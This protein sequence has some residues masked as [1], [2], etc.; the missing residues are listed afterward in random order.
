MAVIIG[1]QGPAAAN[2]V[3]STLLMALPDGVFVLP[4]PRVYG[5]ELGCLVIAP[6]AI[7]HL[8]I[9]DW[10]GVVHDRGEEPWLVEGDDGQ[11]Q[12]EPS[13]LRLLRTARESIARFLADEAP[14]LTPAVRGLLVYRGDKPEVVDGEMR[15][16]KLVSVDEAVVA[17]ADAPAMVDSGLETVEDREALAMAFDQRRLAYRQRASR[18][19]V[20]STGKHARVRRAGW[21]PEEVLH[22]LARHPEPAVQ[23]LL[24]G[25]L[26]EWL[27]TEGALHLADLAT[28]ALSRYPADGHLALEWFLLNSGYMPGPALQLRPAKV[29]L[30]Y[31]L[32]GE[33]ATGEVTID[34]RRGPGYVFG[35][36]TSEDPW[37]SVAPEVLAGRTRI[38]ITGQ[39]S[40]DMQVGEHHGE[41]VI[42]AAG[43]AEPKR[44]PVVAQVRRVPSKWSRWLLRPLLGLATAAPLGAALGWCAA[45][46]L[47]PYVSHGG[48]G[49]PLAI[50]GA[51]LWG[52]MGAIRG[53]QQPPAWPS[54]Y[55][56]AHWLIRV[57][58]WG[59]GAAALMVVSL[60]LTAQL[61]PEA[62]W[63]NTTLPVLAGNAVL[64]C[65]LAVIP[66]TVAEAA[67]NRRSAV[68]GA[69]ASEGQPRPVVRGL[70][71][72]VLLIGLLWGGRALASTP[73]VSLS[74]SAT[75][76][77]ERAQGWYGALEQKVND[78]VDRLYL[79]HLQESRPGRAR[80]PQG[81][82][83]QILGQD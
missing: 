6:S 47:T 60:L 77:T 9:R 59:A 40:A 80:G 64:A 74:S 24:G 7:Y 73:S 71:L 78:Y 3:L 23:Q 81:W 67:R 12:S 4:H 48:L 11:S 29:R 19:F 72:T 15:V 57:A 39:I 82:F 18:P 76:L 31:L 21:S 33:S 61:W 28:E 83:D 70:V 54:L 63:V 13:P 65:L 37:L 32:A 68:H 53:A 50:G 62:A 34:K 22:L 44:I 14:G 2:P 55:A 1:E 51:V 52:I 38:R 42:T 25:S 58:G 35:Q 69:G 41:V 36:A 17:I 43:V 79:Q 16:P 56:L 75:A 66:A 26:S 30:G 20:L 45:L 49:L 8:D 10:S 5:Q 46:L 27:Q